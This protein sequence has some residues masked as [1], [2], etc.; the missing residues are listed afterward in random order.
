MTRWSPEYRRDPEDQRIAAGGLPRAAETR[1]K[2]LSRSGRFTSFLSPRALAAAADARVEPL[3]LVG[4]AVR[5]PMEW[6]D[7]H[8]EPL[9]TLASAQEL[10]ALLRAGIEP[11]GIV[12]GYAGVETPPG[13]ATALAAVGTA[14]AE[15][16]DLTHAVYEARH[17]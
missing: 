8:A 17:L 3:G 11:V 6:R 16:S 1:L 12:G 2:E 14:N 10:W 4:T 7:R 5:L 15:L 13:R 9:L